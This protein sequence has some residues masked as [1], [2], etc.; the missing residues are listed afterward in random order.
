[1]TAMF[2][3]ILVD[4][5]K[6][7]VGKSLAT[8]AL[9]Q[10]YLEQPA[11]SRPRLVVFD[12]DHSNPDV[13][14]KDGMTAGDG[15]LSTGLIDLATEAG[16][17]DF[18]GRLEAVR[19]L[20]CRVIVNMPAQIGNVFDGSIPMVGD[21]LREAHA[22]PVWVL[23]RT[24]ESIRALEHRVSRLPDQYATGLAVRN[25]FFGDADQFVLWEASQ[26]RHRLLRSGWLETELPELNDQLL[27]MMGRRPLHEVV[28][29]GIDHKPLS[30]GYRLALQTWLRRAL[31]A[32]SKIEAVHG[33]PIQGA[34]TRAKPATAD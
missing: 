26:V 21:V 1:M 10:F 3:T 11:D 30:L 28:R 29:V 7:G 24:Q 12:A 31:V 13:C 18:A 23:S 2:R 22:V 9:V 20:D 19:D 32:L 27:V 5:D 14:G 4:G 25:L 34:A 6:G 16:W 17:I 15:I 33:E 8:R